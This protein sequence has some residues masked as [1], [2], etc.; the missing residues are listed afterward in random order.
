MKK[1]GDYHPGIYYYF[2]GNKLTEVK[3]DKI[4]D[5]VHLLENEILSVLPLDGYD[6]ETLYET[7][8]EALKVFISDGKSEI[9]NM[10]TNIKSDVKYLL[11]YVR[12]TLVASFQ[13][14]VLTI[15][16]VRL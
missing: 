1:N 6:I 10:S 15:K 12:L 11:K 14:L 7:K 5:E 2:S 13:L 3:I 8:Q 9:S 16:D 4:E